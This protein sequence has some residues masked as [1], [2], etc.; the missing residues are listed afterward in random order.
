MLH[1]NF[2]SRKTRPTEPFTWLDHWIQEA[3]V[4]MAEV[5]VCLVIYWIITTL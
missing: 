3:C 4:V 1:P 2:G 5:G